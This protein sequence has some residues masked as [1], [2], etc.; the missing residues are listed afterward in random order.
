M[1]RFTP[2]RFACFS[3]WIA[4]SVIG[5]V[6]GCEE[7]IIHNNPSLAG[8]PG[9]RSGM[10]VVLSPERFG[11][12][13]QAEEAQPQDLPSD[14]HPAVVAGKARYEADGKSLRLIVHS[15]ADLMYHI[16]WTVRD[17]EEALFTE[18]LLSSRTRDEFAARGMEPQLA[19]REIRRRKDDLIALLKIMPSGEFT[20]GLWNQPLGQNVF[21]VRAYGLLAQGL[22]WDGFDMVYEKG[23]YRLR[24]F[25]GK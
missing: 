11:G 7:R 8:L 1:R 3:R 18:Q 6:T 22:K 21:R 15:G 14:A 5:L 4:L 12:D 24:W 23:G 16:R 25:T 20:T 10:P 13:P 2:E 17:N 9:A 19:F